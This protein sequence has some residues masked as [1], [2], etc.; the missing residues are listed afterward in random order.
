M[1]NG[2]EDL[3][4]STRTLDTE[5]KVDETRKTRIECTANSCAFH[6][7]INPEASAASEAVIAD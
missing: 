7:Q 1:V 3:F 4:S 6:V 5:V 2:Y